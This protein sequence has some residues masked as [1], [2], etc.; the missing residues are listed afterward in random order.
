M[1]NRIGPLYDRY[2]SLAV[3]FLAIV[4]RNKRVIPNVGFGFV[5]VNHSYLAGSSN[6]EG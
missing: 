3:D 6:G 5:T 1:K 4:T 2:R